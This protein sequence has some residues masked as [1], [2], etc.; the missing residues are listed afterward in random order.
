MCDS[1]VY[2]INSRLLVIRFQGSQKLYVD[3]PLC[4]GWGREEFGGPHPCVFQ[5]STVYPT[6]HI[7]SYFFL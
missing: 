3:F 5:D 4:W 2:V 6:P 1:T 7:V